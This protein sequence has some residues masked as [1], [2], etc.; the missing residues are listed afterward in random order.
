LFLITSV[1]SV[2]LGDSCKKA[3]GEAPEAVKNF[4]LSDFPTPRGYERAVHP[5]L[6][7]AIHILGYVDLRIYITYGF[8]I[9]FH[10]NFEPSGRKNGNSFKI[11]GL[12][13]NF[14]PRLCKKISWLGL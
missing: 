3:L 6:K 4:E 1:T 12:I 2:T 8:I 13:I 14:I 5:P 10:N 9:E 11:T 7:K